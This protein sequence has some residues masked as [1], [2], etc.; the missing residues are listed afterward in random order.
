MSSEKKPITSYNDL[1]ENGKSLYKLIS[2]MYGN[3]WIG[4]NEMRKKNYKNEVLQMFLHENMEE[5]FK[6]WIYCKKKN[7]SAVCV[8]NEINQM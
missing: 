5:L 2:Y 3:D 4:L 8:D 7:M 6:A 1:D